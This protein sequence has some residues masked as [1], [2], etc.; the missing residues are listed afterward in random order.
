V[1]LAGAIP[2]VGGVL[3]DGKGRVRAFWASFSTDAPDQNGSFFAGIPAP[4]VLDMVRPLREGHPFVWRTLGVEWEPI[5]LAEAR[6]FGLSGN[7]AARLE[8]HDPERPQVLVVD[9]V[10]RG[11]PADG[12]LAAGD[13]LLDVGGKPVTRFRE[14]EEASQQPAVS[15]TVLRDGGPHA[16]ALDPV[17]TD[18]AGPR[19]VL[20]WGGAVLQRPPRELALQ[21]GVRLDGVYVAGRFGGSPAQ[22]DGLVPMVRIT[23]VNGS[24]TPD[25]DAFLAAVRKI[26]DRQAVRLR[27]VDLEGRV[28]MR[29]L[30]LD[31]HYW[32][33]TELVRGAR[34]WRRL[35]APEA[36]AS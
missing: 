25:L 28:S 23:A 32:P 29:A 9:R 13:L 30:E 21:R 3:A 19:R 16:V 10:A 6:G 35:P 8:A 7:D 4:I 5:S 1:R 24:P 36:P 26:G 14:V 12:R 17:V 2:S 11:G 18:G 27:T 31:L 22:R 20:V 34:G 33:T 15:M